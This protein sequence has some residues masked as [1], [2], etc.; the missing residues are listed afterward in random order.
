MQPRRG[1]WQPLEHSSNRPLCPA[2]LWVHKPAHT[3]TLTHTHSHTPFH[4]LL[5][6]GLLLVLPAFHPARGGSSPPARTP[7]LQHPHLRLTVHSPGMGLCPSVLL[8]PPSPL[9]GHTYDLT[10]FFLSNPTYG[11]LSQPWVYRSLC[12]FPTRIIPYID[13]F[14]ICLLARSELHV[15]LSYLPP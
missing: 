2:L 7:G 3:D 14:L 13:V 15:A 6:T 8:F 12:Q 9:S 10:L 1:T 11:S 5:P 4:P